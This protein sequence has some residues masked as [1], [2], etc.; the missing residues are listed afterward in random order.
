MLNSEHA[1]KK[2][3][4]GLCLEDGKNDLV[5]EETGIGFGI[6]QIGFD[7]CC[8]TNAHQGLGIVTL[9]RI[10]LQSRLSYIV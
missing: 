9:N 5:L 2:G 4:R 8:T 3:Y 1:I 6:R 7:T 10:L